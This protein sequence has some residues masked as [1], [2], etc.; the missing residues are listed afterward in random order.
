MRLVLKVLIAD[1]EWVI[2]DGLKNFPWEDY[3][4]AVV[5][6]AE[7][8]DEAL[9]MAK[10]HLPDIILSDIKM[11][12][13]S[14]LDFVREAKRYCPGVEIL[15]LTGYDSFEYAQDAI[16]TGIHDYLLK[17]VTSD[18][19]REVVQEVTHKI[20]SQ[21]R[22]QLQYEAFRQRYESAIPMLRDKLAS[23]LL[24]GRLGGRALP[25]MLETFGIEVEKYL[26]LVGYLEE[27]QS[28]NIEPWL[29]EFGIAN[30]EKEILG[31]Y[32]SQVLMETEPRRFATLLLFPAAAADDDCL[33]N[34]T[35]ACQKIQETVRDYVD[36]GI[37]FGI[38]NIGHDPA[39]IR[40]AR[41]QAENAGLQG[42]FFGGGEVMLYRDVKALQAVSFSVSASNRE[43]LYSA[44]SS[45]QNRAV[46]AILET[47]FSAPE[48]QASSFTS[49]QT[50]A[51]ELLAGCMRQFEE[52]NSILS[53]RALGDLRGAMDAISGCASVEQLVEV[54][55]AQL[56]SLA[57]QNGQTRQDYHAKTVEDIQGYILEHFSEDLSL[58]T[59]AAQFSLS[60]GYISRLIK[61][62]SQKSFVEML[63]DLRLEKARQLLAGDDLKIY[64]IAELVGYND[65]SYFISVFKKKYGMTPKKYQSLL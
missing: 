23:D 18:K 37:S 54:M 15:L 27:R 40:E 29:V 45:G 10:A 41:H 4:C 1:D 48:A 16:R 57:A 6:E 9:H 11:P 64:Q 61:R 50:S 14:G 55:D 32:T 7:D 21:Q 51:I 24:H 13:R 56:Q 38:S 22:K 43:R 26:V 30:I 31:K 3:G 2:R 35:L 34:C 46:Q 33:A 47:I 12:G 62:Y 59:V 44:V 60:P 58:D 5:G 53:L 42:A 52:L 63:T 17:P 65:Y 39:L 25:R 49:V 19:L 8:G 36:R 20:E 28:E